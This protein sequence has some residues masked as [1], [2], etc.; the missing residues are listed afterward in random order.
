[1]RVQSSKVVVMALVDIVAISYGCGDDMK[2]PNIRGCTLKARA[3]SL[4][5]EGQWVSMMHKD[6]THSVAGHIRLGC[7]MSR[8]IQ[9]S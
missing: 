1:M 3:K 7:E 8:K 2:F 5:E 6:Y 4:V 9:Q